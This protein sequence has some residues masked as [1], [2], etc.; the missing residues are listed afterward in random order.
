VSV[1]VQGSHL[2]GINIK[3]VICRLPWAQGDGERGGGQPYTGKDGQQYYIKRGVVFRAETHE[4][5]G[6][7]AHT[8]HFKLK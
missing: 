8:V 6:Y 2:P 7:R 5:L 3:Q 4:R 1:G